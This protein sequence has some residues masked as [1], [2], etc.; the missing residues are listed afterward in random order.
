[1]MVV[2]F[3]LGILRRP[4]IEAWLAAIASWAISVVYWAKTN[5]WPEDWNIMASSI[6]GTAIII[7]VYF[8][9]LK[10]RTVFDRWRAKPT[11]HLV[12]K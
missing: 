2:A 9:G 6:I 4:V 7:A 8:I 11:D 3:I 5:S 10:T 1:M 12:G